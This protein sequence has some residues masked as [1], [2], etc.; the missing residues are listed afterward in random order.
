MNLS[1]AEKMDFLR[2]LRFFRDFEP[3][4]L[5]LLA[6]SAPQ[7]NFAA[8]A[9]LTRAGDPV[10]GVLALLSGSAECAGALVEAGAIIGLRSM[11][12]RGRAPAD[13]LAMAS[14]AV[15]EIS[16]D[17]LWRV[18]SEFPASALA[19][20]EAEAEDVKIFI[21]AAE[22]LRRRYEAAPLKN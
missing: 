1:L 18:L 19:A 8:G 4:A 12:A 2:A 7:R 5:R 17:L 11:L 22:K 6:F 13:V 20:R 16:R 15:L 14:G 21:E 3:E 10:D 9:F